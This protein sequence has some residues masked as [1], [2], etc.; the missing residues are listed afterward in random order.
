MRKH[1]ATH[2]NRFRIAILAATVLVAALV[3]PHAA[4]KPGSG[5]HPPIGG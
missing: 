3:G 2:G 5:H 1:E 4:A